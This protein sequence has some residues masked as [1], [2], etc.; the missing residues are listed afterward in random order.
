MFACIC[1]LSL[2]TFD[3]I[4]LDI[5][6]SL[7]QSWGTCY[8]MLTIKGSMNEQTVQSCK[9]FNLNLRIQKLEAK[10]FDI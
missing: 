3:S 5:S 9:I 10:Y 1:E 6:L 8:M 2:N 7:E 4:Y